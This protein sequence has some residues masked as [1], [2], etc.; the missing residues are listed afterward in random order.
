M[1]PGWRTWTSC[2]PRTHSSRSARTRRRNAKAS[3]RFSFQ[4]PRER[5]P[6]RS[7]GRDSRRIAQHR[8]ELRFDFFVTGAGRPGSARN[9]ARQPWSPGNTQV[10]P[11]PRSPARTALRLAA[12]RGGRPRGPPG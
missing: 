3:V 12:K 1:P 8:Q 6:L 11:K 2:S 4:G 10:L 9:E 5:R 7:R